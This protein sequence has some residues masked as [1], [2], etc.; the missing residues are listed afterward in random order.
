MNKMTGLWPQH[1]RILPSTLKKY[2]LKD[3]V[4]RLRWSTRFIVEM[5]Q[6]SVTVLS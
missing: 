1:Y 4:K 6:E 3:G 5:E 2:L